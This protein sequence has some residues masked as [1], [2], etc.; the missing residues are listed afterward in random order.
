MGGCAKYFSRWGMLRSSMNTVYIFP[1]GGPNR[2]FRRFSTLPSI[3]SCVWLAL[4]RAEKVRNIGRN[5][6]GMPFISLFPTFNVFPVPVSPT[7]S[8]CFPATSRRSSRYVYRTVSGVGTMMSAN[9]MSGSH[10]YSG[11]VSIHASQVAESWTKHHSWTGWS[12]G[13]MYCL[14]R[15]QDLSSTSF[16]KYS[17]N[18]T[19]PSLSHDAPMD[20]MIENTKQ[21][22]TIWPMWASSS[23]VRGS[24]PSPRLY[25]MNSESMTLK[26]DLRRFR[27][28]VPTV[29]LTDFRTKRMSGAT[30][31]RNSAL[32]RPCWPEIVA[33]RLSS[34]ETSSG[35]RPR[36]VGSMYTMPHRLTVAGEAT[37]RSSTSNIMVIWFDSWMISPLTRHS[38][39]LSSSTVFMFSIQMASTG[40][41]NTIHF[42][43]G[44]VSSLHSRM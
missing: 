1:A 43:S 13:G 18:F 16:R 37:A 19:R 10:L 29:S 3:R 32:S 9:G 31:A 27:S 34:Q 30:S 33:G 38:F 40:P 15:C 44:L 39:L 12:V 42:L 7:H 26:R 17:L 6:S 5:F 25:W 22:P 23:P 4:V 28:V 11:A 36:A 24:S 20:Q 21:C 2:P 41:S 8:T 35:S 14:A